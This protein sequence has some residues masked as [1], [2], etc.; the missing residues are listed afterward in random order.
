MNK[1]LVKRLFILLTIMMIAL[2]GLEVKNL[3]DTTKKT[4]EVTE[5][6]EVGPYKLSAEQSELEKEIETELLAALDSKDEDKILQNVSR[7][8]V[9][10]Y[11]SLYD[12]TST[13][14][15]GGLGLVFTNNKKEFKT[16]AIN[17]YY[18]DVPLYREVYGAKNLPK[19][20]EIKASKVSNYDLNLLDVNKKD[21]SKAS[22][23]YSI[24]LSW[25]YAENEELDT[26]NIVNK[27]EMILVKSSND[28]YYVFALEG[29]E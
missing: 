19:V 1:K 17:S 18:G 7:Y 22:K 5:Y 26:T 4:E 15:I 2:A 8:F 14:V 25:S 12:K 6:R 20:S 27:A 11:F 28:N 10:D 9:A 3:L 13:N 16:N 29:V 24:D 23:A 21:D